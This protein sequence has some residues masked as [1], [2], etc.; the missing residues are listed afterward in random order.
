MLL[1]GAEGREGVLAYITDC[2]VIG[3]ASL[4]DLLTLTYDQ[5]IYNYNTIKYLRPPR[6]PAGAFL[7]GRLSTGKHLCLRMT[8]KISVLQGKNGKAPHI[9]NDMD[10]VYP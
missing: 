1:V 4:K 10:R 6:K 9:R 7:L 5:I 8:P 2:L 3:W